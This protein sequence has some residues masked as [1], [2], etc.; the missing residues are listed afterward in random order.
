MTPA[1][2]LAVAFAVAPQVDEHGHLPVWPG[3]ARAK[4]TETFSGA[5]AAPAYQLQYR[6]LFL[7]DPEEEHGKMAFFDLTATSF[8]GRPWKSDDNP[9]AVALFEIDIGWDGAVI[10]VHDEAAVRARLRDAIAKV[11]LGG[12]GASDPPPMSRADELVDVMLRASTDRYSN[13]MAGALEAPRKVGER[14]KHATRRLNGTFPT[15]AGHETWFENDPAEPQKRLVIMQTSTFRVPSESQAPEQPVELERPTG[16]ETAVGSASPAEAEGEPT[17]IRTLAR[18]TFHRATLLPLTTRIDVEGGVGP[19]SPISSLTYDFEWEKGTLDQ[20]KVGERKKSDERV[21]YD[22][23]P[24]D[25]AG[26]RT[27]SLRALPPPRYPPMA[28]L[29]GAQGSAMIKIQVAPAG[30]ALQVELD[31][32]SGWGLLDLAAM[33]A[34]ADAQFHPALVSGQAVESWVVVPINFRLPEGY[35]PRFR[36]PTSPATPK[37]SG[38]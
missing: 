19:I 1:I 20:V 3:V 28:I 9:L 6:I 32:T 7:R 34:V 29:A 5:G 27:A 25:A 38:S 26:N 36:R 8:R 17:T 30:R 13:W 10:G 16:D 12:D 24:T 31:T 35:G 18:T 2:L 22:P 4:V 15:Q 11:A 23:N 14:R 21:V 37:P 33:D